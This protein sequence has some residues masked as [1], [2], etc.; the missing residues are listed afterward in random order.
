MDKCPVCENPVPEFSYEWGDV[1]GVIVPTQVECPRCGTYRLVERSARQLRDPEFSPFRRFR[2]SGVIRER[3]DQ[4]EEVLV[5]DVD[6][7]LSSVVIPV[8]PPGQLEKILLH[9]ARRAPRASMSA[10]LNVQNDYPLAYAYNDYEFTLLLAEANRLGLVTLPDGITNNVAAV[11]L[12]L[13]K[14]WP[15]VREL[16]TDR[17]DSWQAFVA[18]WFADEMSHAYIAG[19]APALRACGYNPLRVDSVQHNG[20]IDDRIVAEIRKSGLLIADF[21]GHRGG[22]YFEAGFGLGLGIPVIWT[23]RED[24]IRH[25]HFDTRQY[26]HITWKTPEELRE[27]LLARIE[28]TLATRPPVPEPAGQ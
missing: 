12:T 3:T 1:P 14:G 24:D 18:M 2:L 9:V 17:R 22:V 13:E 25:A 21:T 19:I 26:N 6:E 27:K 7:T 4:G 23:C 8:D 5:G 16:Q 15:R 20:K 28:A 11:R 10:R